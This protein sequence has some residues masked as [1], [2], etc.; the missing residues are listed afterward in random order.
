MK[1]MLDTNVC[2]DYMRGKNSALF[3]RMND[4]QL[5]DLCISSITLSELLYGVYRSSDHIHNRDVLNKL[6]VKVDVLDYDS[7]ASEAYGPIRNDLMKRGCPIGPLDML[8]A[9]HAKSK[10]MILVTHNTSEFMR[11]RGLAVEDWYI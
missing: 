11:V 9:S 7:L 10:Q 2:I 3:K 8:I 5:G 4:C 6:L 1:Y